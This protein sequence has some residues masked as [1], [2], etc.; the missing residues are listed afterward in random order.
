MPLGF[1]LLPD[2]LLKG[3]LFSLWPVALQVVQPYLRQHIGRLFAAHDRDPGIGPGPQK[4]RAVG[5]TAHAVVAGA[6]TAADNHGE[7]RHRGGGHCR[8]HLGAILGYAA[9]LVFLSHHETG[10]VLQEY[11]GNPPLAA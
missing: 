4:A 2:F 7:L 6:E 10:D 1:V 3:F 11:Q 5:A 9:G 8:H